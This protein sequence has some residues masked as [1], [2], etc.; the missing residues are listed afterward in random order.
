[1]TERMSYGNVRHPDSGHGYLSG[2]AAYRYAA[3]DCAANGLKKGMKKVLRMAPENV[4]R[5]AD[6][7]GEVAATFIPR[8]SLVSSK[9]EN[10]RWMPDIDDAP[11]THYSNGL[12]PGIEEKAENREPFDAKEERQVCAH[13]DECRKARRYVE[14]EKGLRLRYVQDFG[15]LV[16]GGK[17]GRFV[18]WDIIPAKEAKKFISQYGWLLDEEEKLE[19]LLLLTNEKLL[20]SEAKDYAHLTQVMINDNGRKK[21]VRNFDDFEQE[22]FRALLIASRKYDS[23]RGARLTSYAEKRIFTYINKYAKFLKSLPMDEPIGGN[24][25][26]EPEAS[27]IWSPDAGLARLDVQKLLPLLDERERGVIKKHFGLGE[28]KEITLEDI[29]RRMGISKEMVRKIEAKAIGK[30]CEAAMQ[31]YTG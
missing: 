16:L 11:E 25:K 29:G 18:G 20:G 26:N 2:D 1:M 28:E 27:R 7:K 30:M 23:A 17:A 21:R 6:R 12:G 5:L 14:R 13:L 15:S 4:M 19:S 3:I 8:D 24:G 10:Y 31:G 9:G 22:G